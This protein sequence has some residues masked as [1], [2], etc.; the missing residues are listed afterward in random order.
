MVSQT[1]KLPGSVTSRSNTAV[2]VDRLSTHRTTREALRE[3][4]TFLYRLLLQEIFPNVMLFLISRHFQMSTQFFELRCVPAQHSE[5]VDE[6]IL[7][8]AFVLQFGFRPQDTEIRHAISVNSMAQS[9]GLTLS[10][11]YTLQS[12]SQALPA[13]LFRSFRGVEAFGKSHVRMADGAW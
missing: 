4:G 10:A 3:I 1:S 8:F 7:G 13:G 9:R 12:F 2:R 11:T 6:L 5:L